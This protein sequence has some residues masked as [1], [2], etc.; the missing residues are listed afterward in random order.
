VVGSWP[1]I[2]LV[3][4]TS[5]S[6]ATS[7]SDATSVG[8]TAVLFG[9]EEE[10]SVLSVDRLDSTTVKMIIEQTAREGRCPACGLLRALVEER[11]LRA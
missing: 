7:M 2:L 9:L 5:S 4:T 3:S 10:F 1:A 8:S 11:P 6:E